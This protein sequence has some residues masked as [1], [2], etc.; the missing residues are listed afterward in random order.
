[1]ETAIFIIIGL[2]IYFIPSITGWKTKSAS[3]I[4]I[5]NLFLGWTVLGWIA[6][7]IWAVSAKKE[8]GNSNY[9]FA[10]NNSKS[11]QDRFVALMKSVFMKTDIT[12][13]TNGEINL[14]IAKMNKGEALI[15]NKLTENYEIVTAEKWEK[16]LTANKQGDYEI[17]EEK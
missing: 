1:M 17:I 13:H 15:K 5:L 9:N 12:Q 10:N 4:L 3:G 6:A 7:L 2:F 14:L 16:I 8:N 11:F